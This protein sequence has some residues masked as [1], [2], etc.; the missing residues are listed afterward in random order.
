MASLEITLSG[1]GRVYDPEP[2][3]V[4]HFIPILYKVFCKNSDL[5]ADE[6]NSGDERSCE[7]CETQANEI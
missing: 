7:R 4:I 6:E 1:K 2:Y 5:S 3:N